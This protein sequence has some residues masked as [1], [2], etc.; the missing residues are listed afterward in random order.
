L[1]PRVMSTCA[2]VRHRCGCYIPPGCR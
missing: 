2:S 1:R